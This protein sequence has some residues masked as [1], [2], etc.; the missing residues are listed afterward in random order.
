MLGLAVAL[1]LAATPAAPAASPGPHSSRAPESE[2]TGVLQ[3]DWPSTPSGKRVSIDRKVRVDE[4]LQKIADAAG[5]N[6]V[7]NTGKVG[8]E[9]LVLHLKDVPVEAALQAVL[10]GTSLSASRRGDAVSV[11]PRAELVADV[12]VLSGFDPPGGKRVSADFTD[13]PVDKALQKIADAGGWSIVLPP[14]LRGAV[15][16]HFHGAPAEEALRAVLSQEGLAAA[17]EGSVVTVSRASGPGVVVRGGKRHY[18]FRLPSVEGS[19]PSKEEIAQMKEDAREAAE[20]AR[21]AAEEASADVRAAVGPRRKDRVHAGNVTVGPGE[22]LR[23]VVAI[24]GDVRLSP[25]SSARQ[26]TAVLG[27]V[28]LE[29]GATVEQEAVAVGGNVHV[30]PGARVSKDVVS[31]GGEVVIDPGGSVDGE[32]VSVSVPGLSSLVGLAGTSGSKGALSPLLR[33]AHALAK[34]AVFF[35]LALLVWVFAPQRLEGVTSA[36]GKQPLKVLLAGLLGTLAMPVLTVLLVVTVVGIP[37]IAVQVVAILVAAIVGYSAL[38]L[39]V[40]RAFPVASA[41]AVLQL[42]LGTA[43]VVVV[44]EVPVVGPM[45]MVS[46][47]LLVFG[48]V[49]RTRFGQAS[50]ASPMP[51]TPAEPPRQAA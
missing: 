31:V 3:G 25:G 37:L 8:D 35:A 36:I 48:A 19:L 23:D 1:L 39:Y 41:K 26:V 17:R 40:G 30:A 29:P 5:W 15:T 6:L 21:Q 10:S 32:Q 14:G 47:W 45:A 20:E 50:A 46:A 16:A 13:T 42:A 24:H 7:A 9:T 27:S 44:S 22:R 11:A 38:A 34:F 28:E 18:V 51:T 49:L 12:P 2:G 33:I 43:L 4:A